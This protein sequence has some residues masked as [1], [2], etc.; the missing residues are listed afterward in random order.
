MIFS[1]INLHTMPHN[2]KEKTDFLNIYFEAPRIFLGMVLQAW[3][4]C[5]WGVSLILICITSQ[6]LLGCMGSQGV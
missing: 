5:I 1:L 4:T 2:D 3:H 6:A